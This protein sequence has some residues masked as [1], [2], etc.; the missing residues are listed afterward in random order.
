MVMLAVALVVLL[1][2]SELM[3]IPLPKLAYVTPDWKLV[4]TAVRATFSVWPCAPVAGVT[5]VMLYALLG[6]SMTKA[7]PSV[8]DSHTALG[9]LV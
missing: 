9:S 3:V 8:A 6:S 1:I 5:L 2:V 7:E 4:P